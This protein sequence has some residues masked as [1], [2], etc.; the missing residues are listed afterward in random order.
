MAAVAPDAEAAPR[1]TP[2]QI[3]ALVVLTEHTGE[4]MMMLSK[5]ETQ[6]AAFQAL[7]EPFSFVQS[8]TRGVLAK[9]MRAQQESAGMPPA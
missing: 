4:H 7:R 1:M 8:V 3:A 2:E 9:A 6:K 5:D